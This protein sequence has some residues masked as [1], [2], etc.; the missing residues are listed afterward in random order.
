MHPVFVI[1]YGRI[2]HRN[3]RGKMN[4]LS[5]PFRQKSSY[6][7]EEL[8]AS[9]N[10]EFG[11]DIPPLPLPPMLMFNR[12]TNI[13]DT[14]GEHDRGF[15]EAELDIR[16]DL[17]FFPAHFAADP[18]MPG[19]LGLDAMWQ[20]LGFFLVWS[21]ARGYARALGGEVRFSGE[22]LPTNQLVQY[23]VDI[24]RV[25]RGKTV[26]GIANSEL[27][28]D[29]KSIYKATDLKTGVFQLPAKA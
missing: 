21:G 9:G 25:V 10:R 24:R 28:C 11:P 27:I 5:K 23:R 7:Y 20:L 18:V 29:G 2:C 13:N 22:V 16:P 14:G 19:C 12:I 1:L 8:L 6:S 4:A 17:W 3:T 15:V 26:V